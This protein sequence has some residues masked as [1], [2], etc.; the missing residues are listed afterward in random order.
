MQYK[1]KARNKYIKAT[2]CIGH[3]SSTMW[4]KEHKFRCGVEN[5]TQDFVSRISALPSSEV[6]NE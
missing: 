5:L 4:R 2:G 1:K 3:I 6:K